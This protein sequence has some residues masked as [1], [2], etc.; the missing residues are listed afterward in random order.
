MPTQGIQPE[1][2]AISPDS[3]YVAY[4]AQVDGKAAIWIRPIG[5]VQA[6][7]LAGTE[8][9]HA[10]FWSPDSRYLAF[11]A[12]GKVKKIGI[13]G[14]PA[15]T[16]ADTTAFA[17]P[18]TWNRDGIILFSA[19]AINGVAPGIVLVP[20]SG[21]TATPVV[22]THQD[23][24]GDLLPQFLPD[25]RH[26]LYVS[27]AG[28]AGRAE[29][30]ARSLDGGSPVHI[31]S[32]DTIAGGIDI[33]SG[34]YA[35]PGYLLFLSGGTLMA[36]RFDEKRLALAGE[37]V[38]LAEPVGPF[39]AAQQVLVYQPAQETAQQVVWFDRGGTLVS[40]VGMPGTFLSLRLSPKGHRL[41]LDQSVGGNSDVW[42]IDLDRGIP[43]RLT[44][45]PAP[46]GTARWSPDEKQI[47]F[48]SM[49]LGAPRMFIRPS[50]RN[51]ND[52][53]LPSETP[54][55]MQDIAEDWSLNGN[56]I[57]FVRAPLGT[58]YSEIW[59]K[60]MFGDGKPFPFV[61]SK[62]F[63]Y[64]EPRVS[65]DS[66]R[67]AY[68]T[69]E[70]GTYQIVVQSFPDPNGDIKRVSPKGGLYPTWRGDGR[71]LYYLALDGKLM[72]VPV[73]DGNKLDF[74]DPIALFQAPLTVPSAPGPA[75]YDVSGDG[76]RF[77]FITNNSINS[78]SPNESG[79]LTAMINWT[80]SLH[81]K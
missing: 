55:N 44:D 71:E 35:A 34:R 2:P 65:P 74:G 43:D 27:I 37:P 69:N 79:K 57:V 56:Y 46:D 16:L 25:G 13:S 11:I 9:G 36:Q 70:S 50:V 61:Q 30:Y 54:S 47:V 39:S 72:A 32:F 21:G 18:G 60:P 22:A 38:P 48:T 75:Q 73:K 5:E 80:T 53:P 1:S 20:D 49:R 4:V 81:K 45:D 3:Q 14:G 52:Q 77:I 28:P 59:V 6:R 40:P 67:I 17:L 8:N 76:K 19:A 42:V 23:G 64:G 31:M 78:A 33:Y 10:P 62:R 24:R 15:T 63:V 58:T 68:T 12:D 26:F 29:L 7:R 66:R 41:A 51:G